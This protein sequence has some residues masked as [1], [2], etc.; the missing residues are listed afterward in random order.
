VVVK[1]KI[2]I[3]KSYSKFLIFLKIKSNTEIQI[4]LPHN[5]YKALSDPMSL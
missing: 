4:A 2:K 3:G 1:I 5:L